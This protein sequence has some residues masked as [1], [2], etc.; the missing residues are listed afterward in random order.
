MTE[1]PNP[2]PIEAYAAI[3]DRYSRQLSAGRG[4]VD[5]DGPSGP[6]YTLV[7]RLPEEIVEPA[8]KAL[9]TTDAD[10]SP[11]YFYA[12][13]QVHLTMLFL[14]PYLEL[15]P[16]MESSEEEE[17]VRQACRPLS[18]ILE[19][20]PPLRFDARGLNLFST[21]V[22]LQLIQQVVEMPRKLR[23]DLAGALRARSS[24][25][26]SAASYEAA[27]PWDLVFANLVRFRQPTTPEISEAV[28]GLRERS[29]GTLTVSSLELVRTDKVMSPSNTKTLQCFR[30]G[31]A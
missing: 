1:P 4:R 5:V 11:H 8:L 3:W 13:S 28:S 25:G 31:R 27:L 24:E 20:H 23:K 18:K 22:F 10:W 12:P 9:E 26:A 19:E 30:L 29:F 14:T 6:I 15:R 17:Y 16:D 7:S 21:T 2:E